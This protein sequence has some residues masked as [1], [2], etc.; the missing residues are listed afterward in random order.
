MDAAVIGVAGTLLGG[1]V[2]GL[3][4]HYNSTALAKLQ[5]KWQQVRLNQEKLE[6]IAALL[7]QID[8]HYKKLMME[9]ILKVENDEPFESS[10]E[11]IPF[12]RLRILMEFYAPAMVGD[13]PKLESAR[14][15]FGKVL[16]EAIPS[17]D[18][19]KPEKQTLNGRAASAQN[20]VSKVCRSLSEKAALLAR[21]AVSNEMANKA[22]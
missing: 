12:E 16:V 15:L 1:L 6:E 7:D 22:N 3:L 14:D 4:T 10:G 13:W 17:A 18:R 2:V 21:V 19:T 8:Q 20:E 11:R 9:V 5:M